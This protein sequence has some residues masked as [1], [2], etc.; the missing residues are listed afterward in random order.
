MEASKDVDVQ[1]LMNVH[2]EHL[3]SRLFVIFKDWNHPFFVHRQVFIFKN[4]DEESV[5]TE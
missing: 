4:G 1:S 3:R 5:C 2:M